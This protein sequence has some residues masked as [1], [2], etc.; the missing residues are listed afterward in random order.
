[1]KAKKKKEN[2]M[3]NRSLY[4]T[5]KKYDH[6]QME[7]YLT[8]VYK[9]GYIDGQNSVPSVTLQDVKEAL[10]GTKGVGPKTWECISDRLE[11]MF[12]TE[13]AKDEQRK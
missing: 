11:K 7:E 13:E 12:E 10:Q 1:M 8:E 5:I 2:Y 6:H 3:I 4:K 9:Y